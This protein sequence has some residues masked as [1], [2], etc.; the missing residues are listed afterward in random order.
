MAQVQAVGKQADPGQQ[1]DGP[2]AGE[3]I[4]PAE[5]QNQQGRERQAEKGSGFIGD[6]GRENAVALLHD[7]DGQQCRAGRKDG[8]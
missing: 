4:I 8:G 7:P 2:E 5:E 1:P 3:S 6:E